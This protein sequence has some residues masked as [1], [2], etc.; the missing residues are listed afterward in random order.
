MTD[1]LMDTN[2]KPAVLIAILAHIQ[3]ATLLLALAN[4][5]VKQ[6]GLVIDVIF[7]VMLLIVRHVLMMI[8]IYAKN[9]KM[10]IIVN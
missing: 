6:D 3:H 9:A 5:G 8:K 4:M 10:D 1:I 7:T 2:A